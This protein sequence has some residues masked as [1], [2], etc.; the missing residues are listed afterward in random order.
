M[1]A[2]ASLRRELLLIADLSGYTGYLV[3]GE[4]E[5]A[6]LIAGD[7]IDTVIGRLV[8]PFELAGL[9]GDA[10][11]L[12]ADPVLVDGPDLMA[13]IA[14]GYDAFRRRVES[15]RLGSSCTCS[16]CSTVPQLDLKFFAH[17]GVVLRQRIAGRDEL[18]GRDVILIHRL[19]KDSAPAQSG[20]KSYAL[21]TD[22]VVAALK[23]DPDAN[24]LRP[25]EQEYEHLG[26]IRGHVLDVRAAWHQRP[27]AGS[28]T[29]WPVVAQLERRVAA[30][31]SVIWEHLT[32]PALRQVW[33]G[34]ESIE[35]V[36]P[37]RGP[38]IGSLSRCVA[39]HLTTIEEIVDWQPGHRL[40]RRTDVPSLGTAIVA[41]R[42][43]PFGGGTRLSVR[44]HAPTVPGTLETPSLERL[45]DRLVDAAVSR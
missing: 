26:V 35:E 42:L 34:I 11:F 28:A 45:V 22:A 41:Y 27:E 10:A 19:M 14:D 29:E 4:V 24:D 37:D 43:T 18:A 33:E 16:A 20:A 21:L 2:P 40:A 1:T 23:I 15:L 17:F 30:P 8:P 7:L 38:G 39:R 5:E 12:H 44:W 3:H 9:E 31:P 32:A 36:G 6:P 13:A 25:V